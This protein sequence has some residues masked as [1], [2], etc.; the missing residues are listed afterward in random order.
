MS[1]T[2]ADVLHVAKLARLELS[3][4]EIGRYTEQ[5]N[6]ILAHAEELQSVD[7]SGVAGFSVAVDWPAPLRADIVGSD[8][9][10]VPAAALSEESRDGFFTVPRL[11]A[12]QKV[13]GQE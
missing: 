7:V 10:A 6:T 5:L 2:A 4:A 1:V 12:M 3:E 13:E 11:A 9:L 8:P